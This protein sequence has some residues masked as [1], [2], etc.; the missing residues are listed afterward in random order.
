VNKRTKRP[1]SD[2]RNSKFEIRNLGEAERLTRPSH[3]KELLHRLGVHPRKDLGQNFLIDANILQMILNAAEPTQNDVILEVGPGLGVLTLPLAAT[4]ATVVAV[5]KDRKLHEHLRHTQLV[6]YKNVRLYHADIMTW[7]MNRE[8]RFNKVIS[9]L[10][11]AAGTRFLVA[12]IQSA[13]PPDCMVVTLQREVC[14]RLRAQP[15]SKAYGILSVWAQIFYNI[16]LIATISPSCFLPA[17]DIRSAAVKLIK[18]PALQKIEANPRMLNRLLKKAFSQR[19]K[20]LT[21]S[22]RQQKIPTDDLVDFLRQ[23]QLSPHARPEELSPHVWGEL[24]IFASSFY[25]NI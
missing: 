14:D 15:A 19:R 11:Y 22:L 17:P 9:N 13:H 4:G 2:S 24:S 25:R 3:V 21:T 23:R 8:E 1:I 7:H 10:P 6:D 5:E 18:R 16:E 20:R 12:A